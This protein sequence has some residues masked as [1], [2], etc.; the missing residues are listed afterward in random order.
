[1]ENREDRSR[2]FADW[3]ARYDRSVRSED[4]F[5]FEGYERVLEE[6]VRLAA[7]RTRMRVLDIGVGTGNLAKRFVARN[8]TVWGVDFSAAMLR[9][10]RGKSP[11]IKLVEADLLGDWPSELDQ[12]FDRVVSAYVFHEFDLSTKIVL[13][14][15]LARRSLA[16]DGRI[17]IG[18]IAFRSIPSR[19]QA[20]GRWKDLWDEQEHYWAA[21]EVMPC[22]EHVGLRG[23]YLQV[24]SCGGVFVLERIGPRWHCG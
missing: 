5:P 10:C 2:L 24:S 13:L 16:S 4:R 3:A 20:Y 6:I 8:C 21:E 17:V 12:A 9:E 22:F 7:V 11:R 1:L 15:R 23:R 18:D 14:G 19:N